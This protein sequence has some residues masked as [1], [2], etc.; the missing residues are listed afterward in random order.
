MI[1][2]S[3]LPLLQERN[4]ERVELDSLKGLLVFPCKSVE[5]KS[6]FNIILALVFAVKILQEMR[7]G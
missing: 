5:T 3:P 1:Q 2:G 6:L 4:A 7:K